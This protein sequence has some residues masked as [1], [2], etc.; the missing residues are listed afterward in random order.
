[1]R[2]MGH[3][4]NTE[5]GGR[6]I[7]QAYGFAGYRPHH[8]NA[9]RLS[10]R[11]DIKARIKSLQ[12]EAAAKTTA[13]VEEIVARL[14]AAYEMALVN[15][16]PSAMVAAAMAKAKLLGLIVDKQETELSG[17][18]GHKITR[19][20]RVIVDA[21]GNRRNADIC[22]EVINQC[23]ACPCWPN[24]RRWCP[25][26]LFTP[27]SS[28]HPSPLAPLTGRYTNSNRERKSLWEPE[29][30]I[31]LLNAPV[32]TTMRSQTCARRSKPATN[33]AIISRAFSQPHG[34]STCGSAMVQRS[35][36][37]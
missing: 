1:M 21:K 28:F 12:R 36:V 15:D 9:I 33:G 27:P 10:Q 14:D 35:N 26:R 5:P 18:V 23:S 19:I 32:H 31:S 25:L 2:G 8:R 17:S 30:T 7:D 3:S 24:A 29:P 11:P 20:E 16:K 6:T 4:A 37:R 34:T 22:P 13:T